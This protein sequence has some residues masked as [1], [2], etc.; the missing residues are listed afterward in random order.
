MIAGGDGELDARSLRVQLLAVL[1]TVGLLLIPSIPGWHGNPERHSLFLLT[2]PVAAVLLLALRLGHRPQPPPPQRRRF[3][4]RPRRRPGRCNRALAALAVATIATALVSEI[5]VHSLREVR[6]RGRARRVLH[7]DRDRRDRRQRGRARRRDR[8]REARQHHGS[9][10]R[11]RSSRRR[12][13]PCSS[14]PRSR[15]SRGSSAAACRCRSA[16]S[17]WRRWRGAALVALRG[18]PGRP[19]AALGGLPAGRRLRRG[20]RS[21]LRGSP[22]TARTRSSRRGTAPASRVKRV[23]RPDQPLAVDPQPLAAL[24]ARR[25]RATPSPSRSK[26]V[27]GRRGGRRRRASSG[28]RRPPTRTGTRC[29]RTTSG[30]AA[31]GRRRRRLGLGLPRLDRAP[32]RARSAFAASS[33]AVISMSPRVPEFVSAA[34]ADLRLAVDEDARRGDR[35]SRRRARRRSAPRG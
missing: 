27:G 17:S 1:G 23:A 24:A 11:S 8:D 33:I 6:A 28:G 25:R 35:P 12:R 14:R 2:L 15:C 13:S 9:R 7:R 34:R 5:L 22:A 31:A 3:A 20:R 26:I 19:L 21:L 32:A 10:P 29:P 30:R 18:R 16:S 4:R